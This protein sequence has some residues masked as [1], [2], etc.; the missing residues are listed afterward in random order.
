MSQVEEVIEPDQDMMLAHMERHFR[1]ILDGR[2]EIAYGKKPTQAQLFDVGDIEEAA[3]FAYE[4]NRQGNNVYFGVAPRSEKIAPFGR[5]LDGDCLYTKHVW[6]DLDDPGQAEKAAAYLKSQNVHLIPTYSIITGRTPHTRAQLFF[7]IEDPVTHMD[8]V[9]KINKQIAF[10]LGGDKSVTNISRVMRVGGSVA[11]PVKEGR[12]PELTNFQSQSVGQ[13]EVDT[14]KRLLQPED[15]PVAQEGANMSSDTG[16]IVRVPTGP[17]GGTETVVDGREEYMRDCVYAAFIEAVGG[18]EAGQVISWQDIFQSAWPVFERHADM[19]RPGHNTEAEMK[20]KCSHIL[21]RFTNG[22]LLEFANVEA[23][24]LAYLKR[25]ADKAGQ[26]GVDRIIERADTINP[27][28]L[29]PVQRLGD[30][31]ALADVPQ[32]VRGTLVEGGMSV[33]YGDSNVGKSFWAIDMCLCVATGQPWNN[34]PVIPGAVVYVA[35]EG[36]ATLQNRIIAWK[37]ENPF[38]PDT[39]F[40][41]IPASVN[42]FDSEDEPARLLATIRQYERDIGQP[43]RLIVLDTLARAMAGGNENAGED[44]GRMIANSD[45]LRADTGAHVM[46]VHHTGKDTSR[47]ARGH[48]SLRAATDTEIELSRA[49]G[50]DFV[51]VSM[52]KQR[53][54][55]G[56]QEYSFTLNVVELG[57]DR[58]GVDVTSCTVIHHG[59]ASKD[60]RMKLSARQRDIYDCI[61]D[62]LVDRG[63]QKIVKAGM[64]A[65]NTITLDVVEIE[66]EKRGL[67]SSDNSRSNRSTLNRIKRE[68]EKAGLIGQ[69]DGLMWLIKT[70]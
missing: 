1:N 5:A 41:V 12:V 70:N 45:A 58:Y 4:K 20:Q 32:L 61:V 54:L 67:L 55:E 29:F 38:K 34:R 39:P 36:G 30:M 44:M 19:Q 31:N 59:E 42:M 6:V 14:I 37:K 49:D 56:G 17:L 2:I 28:H 46:L 53:D 68:L 63:E 40:A 51:N 8:D 9:T 33:V 23:V 15:S 25:E 52:E 65:V 22:Q 35:M 43:V 26:G 3:A 62:M 69:Y 24:Q 21:E 48:S 50:S 27:G 11:W 13:Y 64:P 66:L 7:E 18:A 60:P 16:N 10:A 47:G 57:K